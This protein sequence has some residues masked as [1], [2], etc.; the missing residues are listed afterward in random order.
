MTH[1]QFVF[2]KEKFNSLFIQSNGNLSHKVSGSSAQVFP[3]SATTKDPALGQ[4]VLQEITGLYFLIAENRKV[5]TPIDEDKFITELLYNDDL[6]IDED[7]I[8]TFRYLLEDR[9]FTREGHLKPESLLAL[10]LGKSIPSDAVQDLK[11][12]IEKNASFLN[13]VLG[14]YSSVQN[15][16]IEAQSQEVKEYDVLEQFFYSNLSKESVTGAVPKPNRFFKVFTGFDEVFNAD[17]KYLLLLKQRFSSRDLINLLRLYYF[18]YLSQTFITLNQFTAGSRDRLT[19]LYFILSWEKISKARLAAS[20]NDGWNLLKNKFLTLFS[21]Q[22]TLVI[23]NLIDPIKDAEG[24]T[25]I[26]DYIKLNQYIQNEQLQEQQ[27]A[28]QI[29]EMADYYRDH[30]KDSDRMSKYSRPF[31]GIGTVKEEI[32]YLYDSVRIQFEDSSRKRISKNYAREFEKITSKFQSNRG[33]I[34]KILSIDEEMLLFLTRISIKDQSK[35]R[36]NDLFKQFEYRGIFLDNT[37]KQET[38][39]FFE[40]LNLIEKKSD[41]GDAKYVK[42]L[43]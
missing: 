33:R 34:G 27:V 6:E 9:F 7:K 17:L 21:Q 16:L 25:V 36:L 12:I 13:A 4:E 10:E 3:F 28:E 5:T 24:N 1:T 22:V 41:S 29:H 8:E 20:D 42:N 18:S 40:K 23:L 38:A 30:I 2:D 14:T 43:Q 32:L 19:P 39:V 15:T 11:P 26:F 35:I 31:S 37:S